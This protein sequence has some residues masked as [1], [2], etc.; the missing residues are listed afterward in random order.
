M[1]LV[2]DP[3]ANKEMREAAFFYEDCRKGLGEEFLDLIEESFGQ[4]AFN[5]LR[6]R[7]LRGRYRR[8]LVN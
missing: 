7:I 4:I 1:K 8:Y 6:W 3:A 5:P 2:L